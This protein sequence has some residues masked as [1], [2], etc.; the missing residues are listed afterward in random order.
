VGLGPHVIDWA[1]VFSGDEEAHY[2]RRWF[3]PHVA[4]RLLHTRRLAHHLYALWTQA[5]VS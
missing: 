4:V 3:A 2:R 5:P 1:F